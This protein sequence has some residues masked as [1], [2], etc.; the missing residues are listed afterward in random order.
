MKTILGNLL[1]PWANSFRSF[2]DGDTFRESNIDLMIADV[3]D[4]IAY[5]KTAVDARALLTG[6][7][8]FNGDQVFMTGNVLFPS[9]LTSLEIQV[10]V[11]GNDVDA[12]FGH[13]TLSGLEFGVGHDGPRNRRF[14][15]PDA[16]HTVSDVNHDHYRVPVLSAG[17]VYT[18]TDHADYAGRRIRISRVTNENFSVRLR[19]SGTPATNL[20][21][22]AAG[23]KFWID[24]E[25]DVGGVWRVVGWYG[26]GIVVD[27]VEV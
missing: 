10:D 17:V 15:L 18:F 16:T 3:A 8:E 19:R 14:I 11:N 24:M 23:E 4:R 13:M 20:V 2:I 12:N 6:N 21:T 5:L 27:T 26:T 25:A 1:A 7:N 9:S 22:S